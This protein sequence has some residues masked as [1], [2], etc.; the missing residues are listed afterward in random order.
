MDLSIVIPTVRP[1]SDLQVIPALERC[2]FDD[3]EVILRDDVPVTK[4]RNEGYRA[5]R[6]N[7]IVYL[8]D[9]S[10]PR[11]GYL[12]EASNTLATEA[13]VAGRTIHPRDDVF[14]GQLTSH[15]DFGDT[16]CLV[17]RFWGC[18][19][20]IRREVLKDVGGWDERMGWGHEEK[21]LAERV[22][23]RYDIVYNPQMVVEHVYAE[24]LR[25]YWRKQYKLERNTPYFLGKHGASRSEIFTWTVRQLCSP[26]NYLA[27]QPSLAVARTGRTFAQAAGR[28]VGLWK[29]SSFEPDDRPRPGESSAID[30]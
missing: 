24:S 21:E 10:A 18:N 6:S 28:L 23:A 17:N 1:E 13:A 19:M 11:D 15:Y 29:A 14:A 26:R 20:G 8:D 22:D 5:A 27:R 12:T 9:D 7:K 16:P 25:D 2:S 4:A 30:T 3:Y